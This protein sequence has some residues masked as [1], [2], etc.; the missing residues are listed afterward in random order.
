MTFILDQ[1]EG[2]AECNSVAW[3]EVR[4][5]IQQHG[6]RDANKTAIEQVRFAKARFEKARALRTN[7]PP[8]SGI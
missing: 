7:Q 3:S 8:E 2:Y 5:E 6:F 4:K 1:L